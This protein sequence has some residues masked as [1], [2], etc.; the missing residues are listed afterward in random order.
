VYPMHN[1]SCH[2]QQMINN[3]KLNHGKPQLQLWIDSLNEMFLFKNTRGNRQRHPLSVIGLLFHDFDV[4]CLLFHDFDVI[5]SVIPWFWR[6]FCYKPYILW[7]LLMNLFKPT[8]PSDSLVLNKFM[9]KIHMVCN[10]NYMFDR[11]MTSKSW[12]NRSYDVKIME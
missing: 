11:S 2:K 9:S 4:I 1:G 6:H 5:G 8:H 3:D 12:N 7:I 10:R